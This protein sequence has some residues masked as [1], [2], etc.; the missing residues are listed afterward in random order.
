M[1]SP[2]HPLILNEGFRGW[3]HDISSFSLLLHHPLQPGGSYKPRVDNP[4]PDM[5][6]GAVNDV[7]VRESRHCS[8]VIVALEFPG[9]ILGKL[10]SLYWIVE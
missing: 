2:A 9:H 6:I 4:R 7:V 1:P 10:L 5:W 3:V 8:S